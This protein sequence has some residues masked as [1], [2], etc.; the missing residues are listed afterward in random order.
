[1]MREYSEED[2]AE[3][4]YDMRVY[5]REEFVDVRFNEKVTKTLWNF[6]DSVVNPNTAQLLPSRPHRS[7]KKEKGR[8]RKGR[9]D[10]DEDEYRPSPVKNLG[11]A[12]KTRSR[13]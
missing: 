8:K 7:P 11:S 3:A 5:I 10:S 13:V 9:D 1:M 4:I 2:C 12:L 6:A